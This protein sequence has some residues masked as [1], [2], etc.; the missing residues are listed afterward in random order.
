MKTML[1]VNNLMENNQKNNNV[2]VNKKWKFTNNNN[3]EEGF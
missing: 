1:R 3:K 2:H